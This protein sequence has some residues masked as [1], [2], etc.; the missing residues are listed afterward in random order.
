MAKMTIKMPD[1]FCDKLS[2]LGD[3]T[4]AIVEKSLEAG[5]DVILSAAR[6][7]LQSVIGRDL[8]TKS[9]ST[10]KLFA[11]LGV[12]PVKIDS[13]GNSNIKIG[14]AENRDPS[15]AKLAGILEHGKHGQSAKP[16][17]KPAASKAKTAAI[18]AM[19]S[20]FDQEAGTL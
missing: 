3:K 15:N 20:A 5:G 16:F 18:A 1:E 6:A 7:N 4:D 8:K 12:S 13:Q 19:D 9:R 2:R 11:S 14:F 10:G 17:M